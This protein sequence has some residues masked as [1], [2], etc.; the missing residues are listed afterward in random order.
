MSDSMQF[1]TH[2]APVWRDRANFILHAKVVDGDGAG[3]INVSNVAAGTSSPRNTESSLFEQL[4]TRRIRRLG[5]TRYAICCIPFFVYDLN[6]GDEVETEAAD[7]LSY[8]VRRVVKRS[9]HRTIRVWFGESSRPAAR[10]EVTDELAA[11]GCDLEWSSRS[12]L[13]A[14]ASSDDR[15]RDA[16]DLLAQRQALGHLLFETGWTC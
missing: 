13:A 12:L 1:L 2:Q 6:L 5:K 8:V 10:E 14:D 16:L 15:V 7:G 9:G 4:W 3:T 11:L